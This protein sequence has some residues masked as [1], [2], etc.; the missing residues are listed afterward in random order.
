MLGL[1]GEVAKAID[2]GHLAGHDDDGRAGILDDAGPLDLVVGAKRRHVVDRRIDEG[3][4]EEDLAPGLGLQ[5]FAGRAARGDLGK[6]RPLEG[7]EGEDARVDHLD[8]ELRVREAVGVLVQPVEI[9]TDARAV[10]VVDIDVDAEVVVL[11]DV[12]QV[13]RIVEVHGVVG[14]A[15]AAEPFRA[16]LP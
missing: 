12:A 13:E 14:H 9:G 16:A 11:P 10:E 2:R 1:D 4:A 6:L 8:L 3:A 15:V 5:R 7:A